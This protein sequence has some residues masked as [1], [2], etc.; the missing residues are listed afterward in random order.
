MLSMTPWSSMLA[1][2]LAAM[3]GEAETN[4][5]AAPAPAAATASA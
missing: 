4:Q 1:M 2:T 5:Q 3:L